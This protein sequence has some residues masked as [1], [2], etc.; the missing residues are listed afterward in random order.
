VT[1]RY[2]RR[3]LP[4]YRH[5]PGETPHP[6][7]SAR[8]HRRG[9]AAAAWPA[10][11]ALDPARWA[12]N[13]LYLYGV[14]LFNHGYFWEAHAAWESLWRLAKG[15]EPAASFLQ[16][17]IQVAAALVRRRAG[18]REGARRLAA[19]GLSKLKRAPARQY[20]GVDVAEL[21]A[22]VEAHLE[23]PAEASEAAR[24]LVLYFSRAE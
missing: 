14:D 6:E 22:R 8:G 10:P 24:L 3:P 16:G 4:P 2:T 1:A 19:R 18:A 13:E 21:A 11:V 17:L 15:Q 5:R 20:L 7:R 9:E 12:E 23:L